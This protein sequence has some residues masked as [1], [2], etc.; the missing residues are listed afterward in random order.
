MYKQYGEID[1]ALLE[2]DE[3]NIPKSTYETPIYRQYVEVKEIEQATLATAEK[4][5]ELHV[6]LALVARK[7]ENAD[8][9]GEGHQDEDIQEG[10]Q[11]IR[12]VYEGLAES[13][14]N[15]KEDIKLLEETTATLLKVFKRKLEEGV[16]GKPNLSLSIGKSTAKKSG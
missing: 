5:K 9:E 11:E 6:L 2:P 15:M 3:F 8:K 16:D 4:I 13:A 10:V 7:W 14:V 12:D 1:P